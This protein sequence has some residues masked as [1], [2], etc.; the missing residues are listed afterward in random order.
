MNFTFRKFFFYLIYNIIG[1]SLPRTYMPYSIG[2]KYIR[3]FLVKNFVNSFG[4]NIKIETNVLLSPFIDI[5]NNVEINE[6]VRIRENVYIG[7]NVL[8]APGV[9][10]LSTNHGSS[11]IDIPIKEQEGIHGTI[12]IN[13]DVWIGTNA[14]ILK[15][16]TIGSHSIIA[17]GAIVTKNVPEYSIV[18]GVPAKI[19]K[20]RK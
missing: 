2:S 18:A 4:K 7:C 20:K 15:D 19:I 12:T 14:I 5:G 9:Q 1:K 13:D 11:R 17:A 3:R 6:N 8:I 16:V 10:L